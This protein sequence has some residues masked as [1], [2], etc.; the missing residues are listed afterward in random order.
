MISTSQTSRSPYSFSTGSSGSDA[1]I[2]R[3]VV[4]RLPVFLIDRLLEI[5]FPV[6]QADSDKAEA[7]IA[8][9]TRMI[10]RQ[11]AKPSGG[12]RQGL[13]KTV[14][15]REVGDRIVR[16]SRARCETPRYPSRFM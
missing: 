1:G 13:V 8:G 2:Q 11:N 4:F 6:K 9:G 7:E 5:A 14:F 12:D 10:P 15:G 16:Q 3:R